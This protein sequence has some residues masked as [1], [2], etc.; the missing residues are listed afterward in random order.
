MVA[1]VVEAQMLGAQAQQHKV[2]TVALTQLLHLM[3]QEV[4]GAREL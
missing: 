2:L 1:N 4:A 3:V